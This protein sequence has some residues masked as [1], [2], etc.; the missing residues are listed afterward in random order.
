MIKD[1]QI[2]SRADEY[3]TTSSVTEP[4]IKKRMSRRTLLLG[5]LAAGATLAGG[6]ALAVWG[7]SFLQQGPKAES[8][9]PVLDTVWDGLAFAWLPDSGHLAYASNRGL[10]FVDMHDGQQD[11]KQKVWPDYDYKYTQTI[12]YSQDQ[13]TLVYLSPKALLV[14]DVQSGQ[15]LWTYQ[16][17]QEPANRPVTQTAVLSPD[18]RYLA[19]TCIINEMPDTGVQIWDVQKGQLASQ[20]SIQTDNGSLVEISSIIWSPDASRIVVTGRDGSVQVRDR[21]EDQS[22]WSYQNRAGAGFREA[23]SWSP[24]G[25]ALAFVTTDNGTQL[26]IWDALSGETRFVTGADISPTASPREKNKQVSWSPDGA[27]IAFTTLVNR[28]PVV[29]VWSVQSGQ[30][31]FS[32][33]V[34]GQL[35]SLAWSPDGKYLAAGIYIGNSGEL[36]R[37]DNGDRSIVQFW[38]GHDGS[39]F[40]ALS[41]PKSPDRLSWSP[42]SRYLAIITPKTYGVLPQSTCLSQCR[43]GYDNEALQVFQVE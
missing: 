20:Q 19:F 34:Q 5:G 28:E 30:R 2:E 25:S 7:S 11:W 38:N 4:P 15:N 13:T 8:R 10:F 16:I 41:A 27:Q 9:Q 32:C 14:Q 29:E 42:D 33:Q 6:G 43:Y 1:D 31:L 21:V 26:G 36:E 40:F 35:T 17:S 39:A 24:A 18:G 12:I 23:I 37:G 3:S 22:V